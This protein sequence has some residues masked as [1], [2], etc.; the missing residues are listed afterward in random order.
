MSLAELVKDKNV[1]GI[2]CNQWGDTGKGKI[3]DLIASDWAEI[4]ARGTGGNN[5]GHTVIADGKELALHLIP[6]GK[7]ALCRLYL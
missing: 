1:I 7:N 4:I 5:A 6:A 3:S 2:V